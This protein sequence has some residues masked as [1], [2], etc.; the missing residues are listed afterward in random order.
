[1][2][3]ALGFVATTIAGPRARLLAVYTCA[4]LDLLFIKRNTPNG[5]EMRLHRTKYSEF[6]ML[7]VTN[8]E[9]FKNLR[10]NEN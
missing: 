5:F 10:K 2:Y 9:L 4:I 6:L 7:T 8:E 1:M 3:S